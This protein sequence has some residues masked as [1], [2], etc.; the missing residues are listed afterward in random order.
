MEISTLIL[1]ASQ[2]A[3]NLVVVKNLPANAGD[4]GDAVFNPWIRTSPGGGNGN[5]LQYSCLR[6]PWAEEPGRLQSIGLQ[7]VGLD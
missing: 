5:S 4:V 2:M 3:Q 7:R 6:I 1:E